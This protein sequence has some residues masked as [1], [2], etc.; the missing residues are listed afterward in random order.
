MSER[1]LR[2]AEPRDLDQLLE[3]ER[4]QFPEPWTRSMLLDEIGNHDSRRYRVLE[5][6]GEIL[7]YAGVM[8]V[9][10]DELHLNSIAT[11]PGF[12]GSGVARAL[13]DD[14]IFD[15][16]NR[17]VAR[18]TLEVAASNE[19]AQ[20]LYYHYGFSPVGVRRR[21]YSL[22]GEDALIMWAHWD[23]PKA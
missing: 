22:T 2:D 17:G 7:G 8:F 14:L 11:K 3:I 9:L 4:A 20:R 13:M 16:E 10:G 19:R 1:Q 5:L 6:A 12:E 21:Y 18:A 23:E 15:A